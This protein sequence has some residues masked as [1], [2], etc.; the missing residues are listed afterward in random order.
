[1]PGRLVFM[2]RNDGHH[3]AALAGA[4]PGRGFP[5]MKP[6]IAAMAEKGILRQRHPWRTNHG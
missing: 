2:R 3:G 1:M 5:G 4:D 6:A